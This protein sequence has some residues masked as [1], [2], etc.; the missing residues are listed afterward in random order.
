MTRF[1]FCCCWICEQRPT[2]LNI[3][4]FCLSFTHSLVY[5]RQPSNGSVPT[6]LT[7]I[8]MYQRTTI[9]PLRLLCCMESPKVRF[10]DLFCLFSIPPL[11]PVLYLATLS[12]ITFMQMTLS[13]WNPF[14]WM[15]SQ[16][17]KVCLRH[18]LMIQKTR[19]QKISWDSMMTRP[20]PFPL[21]HQ[22]QFLVFCLLPLQSIIWL[23]RSQKAP[24][25][26]DLS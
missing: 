6:C 16:T 3:I 1:Q 7:D 4:F 5:S 10:F 11:C 25:T 12:V 13:F 17:L 23:F 26:W 19:W 2:Q 24:G 15:S 21:H 20:R 18:V 22:N 8:S 9:L 14:V